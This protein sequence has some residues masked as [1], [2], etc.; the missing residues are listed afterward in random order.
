MVV[1]QFVCHCKGGQTTALNCQF[2]VNLVRTGAVPSQL[3]VQQDRKRGFEGAEAIDLTVGDNVVHSAARLSAL[4]L[5]L[6]VTIKL[7]LN[8]RKGERNWHKVRGEH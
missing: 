6:I 4:L 8:T 5:A 7:L 2:S 3:I 1:L